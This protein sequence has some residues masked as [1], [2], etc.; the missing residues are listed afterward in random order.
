M[1]IFLLLL[2]FVAAFK[3]RFAGREFY[4]HDYLSREQTLCIN[5]ICIAYILLS[6]T[7]AISANEGF[8]TESFNAVRI[9]IGQF[10]VVPIL[11]FSGFGIMESIKHKQNY[12]KTFPKQRLL[13][14]YIKFFVFSIPYVIINFFLPKYD[15]K[16]VFLSFT[17][18][19]SIGNGG[20][21]IGVTL[22]V[23]I[24]VI[25]CF[26][27]FKEKNV[28]AVASVTVLT[29]VLMFVEMALDFPTYYYSTMIFMP[30]GMCFSLIKDRFDAIVMKNN[31]VW[32]FCLVTS[33]LLSVAFNYLAGKS[34]VF[35]P[36]WCFFGILSIILLCMKVRI[37]NIIL[38]WLGRTIFFNFILQGI[39][40]KLLALLPL[41][42]IVY[43]I[44]V[45]TVTVA[46]VFVSERSYTSI[47]NLLKQ[48]RKLT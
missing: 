32:A 14:F 29:A 37:N 18:F 23:Y 34:F 22:A 39:P 42:D 35:Y 8:L 45:I 33:L 28:L 31:L 30:I 43:Y 25:I 20:W 36:V 41:D 11:F 16:D 4:S 10:P 40:Q 27:I 47:Q 6:H 48:K 3:L 7:F 9:Y 46:L 2:L 5:G 12:I 24:F 1:I 19:V 17:G 21:Y 44:L 13:D 15:I 38:L 26:N